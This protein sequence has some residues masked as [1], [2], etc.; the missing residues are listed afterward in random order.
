[1]FALESILLRGVVY[2][3]GIG[4]GVDS[5]PGVE[6]EDV[7]IFFEVAGTELEGL[8]AFEVVGRGVGAVG[9]D[10][11]G[12]DVGG[13]VL[14]FGEG[15]KRLF[16]G[17]S[18]SGRAGGCEGFVEGEGCER[19]RGG[20]GLLHCGCGGGIWKRRS[21]GY[22]LLRIVWMSVVGPRVEVSRVQ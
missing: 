15:E 19:G 22:C 18:D 17:G 14:N 2:V 7:V 21:N 4:G 9:G 13:Y 16:G 20:S 1:M 5:V 8:G 10:G 6:L 3:E 11:G 12:G